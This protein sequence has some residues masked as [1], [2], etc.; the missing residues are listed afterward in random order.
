MKKSLKIAEISIGSLVLL[1]FGIQGFLL[2]GTPGQS[3]SPQNYQDKVDYSSVPTLLI[4]GWGGSTI[5]YNKMI[6]YYQQKN[7]AQKVL[8]IWVAPN[9]RIWTEGNF[10]GQ[11]NALIQVL[12]TW[13]YNG[14]YHPQIKQLKTV[15]NYLQKHYHMQKINVVAHSYGGTEFIHAYMGSKYLQDHMR[16]N[17]V[18]FLGVP[19]EESLSDQLKYRYHLVNKSTDKNFHQL[20]LEM[21]NWQLNYPVEIY[22]LMGSEEGSKTTDGAVP[23]IQSEMLKSLVKAHPSIRYHQKVYPKTTHF[24]LHHRTKIL[25]NIANILW[26][27]N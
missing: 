7:I 27:R 6:K 15:L 2:R 5:T 18:V 19:V 12:F 11:K 16:L 22:N 17:K 13:N 20:F 4:P 8:T 14:T 1:A 21:K 3:L 10:H 23:H 26:G 25:N 24:Q 9:G